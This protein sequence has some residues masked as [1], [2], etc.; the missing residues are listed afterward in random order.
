L[1]YGNL[2]LVWIYTWVGHNRFGGFGDYYHAP[3]PVF[4]FPYIV[5]Q[6]L[7]WGLAITSVLVVLV[8]LKAWLWDRRGFSLSGWTAY[9]CASYLWIWLVWI[10]PAFFYFV[11][12]FHSLQYLAFV[13]RYKAAEWSEQQSNQAM[14]GKHWW[15]LAGFALLGVALGGGFMDVIPKYLDQSLAGTGLMVHGHY[16][17]ISFLLFINIHHYFIDHAMWRRDNPEVQRF[18]FR[19]PV[20]RT[21][22]SAGDASGH[23][24]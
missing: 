18:I 1:L 11:P 24:A 22:E 21:A 9:G 23:K 17:I 10:H 7:G 5:Q 12:L 8:A 6:S 16:F 19:Q 13:Y 2:Y 3:F 20:V 14:E 4:R 15:P